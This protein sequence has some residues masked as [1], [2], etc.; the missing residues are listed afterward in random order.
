MR[1]VQWFDDPLAV[2]G[3]AGSTAQ[4][5]LLGGG[6]AALLYGLLRLPVRAGD[7]AARA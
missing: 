4:V 3:V 1:A 6:T 2:S 5:A 7:T